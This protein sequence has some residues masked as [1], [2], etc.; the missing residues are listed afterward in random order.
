MQ[1][2]ANKNCNE[3]FDPRQIEEYPKESFWDL[4]HLEPKLWRAK[5]PDKYLSNNEHYVCSENCLVEAY[6]NSLDRCKYYKDSAQEKGAKLESFYFNLFVY[7]GIAFLLYTAI[8]V[9]YF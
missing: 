3:K 6:V 1:K 4:K 7:G 5:L 9:N 2:S 8:M